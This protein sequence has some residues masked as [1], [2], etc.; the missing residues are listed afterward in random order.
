MAGEAELRAAR[1]RFLE[2]NVVN[3]RV[4]QLIGVRAEPETDTRNHIHDEGIGRRPTCESNDDLAAILVG[5]HLEAA[6]RECMPF[7]ARETQGSEP[8]IEA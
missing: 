5:D 1:H 6:I 4:S 3:G 2:R 7:G 8:Y